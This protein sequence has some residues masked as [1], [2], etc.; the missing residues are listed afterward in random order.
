MPEDDKGGKWKVAEVLV[1]S[2]NLLLILG[3]IFVLL[4]A[5]GGV[6][7]Q[8]W[9][10]IVDHEWRIFLVIVGVA[11]FGL[12]YWLPKEATKKLSNSTVKLLCI[13]I[14]YPEGNA[15]ISGQTEVRG[16]IAKPLPAGYELCILRGY[17]F[18]GFI[19]HSHC[20]CDPDKKTWH[21]QQFDVGGDKGDDRRIEAWLVGPDGRIVLD[22]WLAAH[23]LLKATN[24]RVRTLAP[25]QLLTWLKPITK[26]TSDMVLCDWI[27][28]KRG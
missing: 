24:S 21:V 19:P 9:F 6:T 26:P 5:S 1:T 7:Y 15:V 28:V 10:S 27:K 14:I 4:G 8:Q 3:S 13:T 17:P 16:T 25:D 2:P 11:L 20:F 12:Y 22:T 23:E 18:G